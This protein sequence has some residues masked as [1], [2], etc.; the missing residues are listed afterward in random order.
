LLRVQNTTSTAR[1][2][3][4]DT[5]KAAAIV[6]VVLYHVGGT[7]ISYLLPG[8]E[9]W[10]VDAWRLVNSALL[11]VRMP[12]FFLASGL[13]AARAVE[14][15]WSRLWRPRLGNLLWPFVLWSAVFAGV[16]GLAYAPEDP[17][18][19]T[20]GSL[21]AIP[22]GG[23]AYWYLATLVVFF[24]TARLLR[25]W[26][27]TV[28]LI[29]A[30]ALGLA[31]HVA[32]V[33]TELVGPAGA[34]NAARLCYFALWYFAGCFARGVVERIAT[35]NRVPLLPVAVVAFA[36][37]AY[38]VYVRDVSVPSTALSLTGLVAAVLASRWVSGFR[39][40]RRLSR[41]LAGRTLPIYVLHPVLINLLI[42]ATRPVG[43]PSWLAQPW[44]TALLV[45]LLTVGLTWAA[46]A[47]YDAAG[48]ARLGWLFRAPG[49]DRSRRQ[50]TSTAERHATRGA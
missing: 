7:G 34:A 42:I 22:V 33:L 23:T 39:P 43:L 18:A 1:V 17:A 32:P 45:P 41:Y 50:E 4:V 16:S 44:A 21:L 10:G 13:L 12:L 36:A 27:P 19:Y 11:P 35:A 40:A 26:A 14:R 38:L 9:G 8:A 2:D 30:V 31:P 37:L 25:A 5:A 3:W 28:L 47:I 46:V 24:V 20:G 29:S 15:D 48:R 49:G 6:L